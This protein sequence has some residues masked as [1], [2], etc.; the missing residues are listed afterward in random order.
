MC[1]VVHKTTSKLECVTMTTL[2]LAGAKKHQQ[3]TRQE[4]GFASCFSFGRSDG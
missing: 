3:L 4:G 2:Y 1:F